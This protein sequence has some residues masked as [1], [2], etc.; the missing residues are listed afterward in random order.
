MIKFNSYLKGEENITLADLKNKK[1]NDDF[2]I[3]KEKINIY[4]T[5]GEKSLTKG[6]ID[7]AHA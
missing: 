1:D 6:V 4:T 5:D 2:L 3:E 7:D